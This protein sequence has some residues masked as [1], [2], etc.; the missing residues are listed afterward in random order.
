MLHMIKIIGLNSTWRGPGSSPIS[1]SKKPL[2]RLQ[3][4]SKQTSISPHIKPKPTPPVI[5]AIFPRQQLP[6]N[7][8]HSG[9]I[10]PKGGRVAYSSPDLI[11][12]PVG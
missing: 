2:E 7:V 4:Q 3:R 1:V 8:W 11:I 12:H 6:E 5:V 9:W 10:G